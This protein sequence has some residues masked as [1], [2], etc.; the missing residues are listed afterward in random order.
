MYFSLQFLSNVIK[1]S[2]SFPLLFFLALHIV[3]SPF[4]KYGSCIIWNPYII[5]SKTL[6]QSSTVSKQSGHET[7]TSPSNIT[8]FCFLKSSNPLDIIFAKK[9]SKSYKS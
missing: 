2:F 1:H 5:L 9:Q 7:H 8:V 3:Q 4:L 6:F